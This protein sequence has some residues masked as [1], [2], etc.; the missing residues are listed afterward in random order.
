MPDMLR[1]A[2]DLF[3]LARIGV[4]KDVL[5]TQKY[6]GL[7]HCTVD[8]ISP[9]QSLLRRR[10]HAFVRRVA[11]EHGPWSSSLYPRLRLRGRL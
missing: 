8:G 10:S 11:S 2:G 6:G 4:K 3:L 5:S 9:C 7:L 1:S